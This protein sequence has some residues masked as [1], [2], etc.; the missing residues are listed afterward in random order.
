M[1]CE[2]SCSCIVSMP[3][4]MPMPMLYS[5][6]LFALHDLEAGV[7]LERCPFILDSIDC[8][9][10]CS[11]VLVESVQSCSV[12]SSHETA[13]RSIQTFSQYTTYFVAKQTK[14]WSI[15]RNAQC[16]QR[17]QYFYVF[18]VATQRS[19]GAWKTTSFSWKCS[20][21]GKTCTPFC[22]ATD[23]CT[24]T[25]TMPMSNTGASLEYNIHTHANSLSIDS[26]SIRLLL[27]PLEQVLSTQTVP[28]HRAT[29][30]FLLLL[31]MLMPIP[32]STC[33]CQSQSQ[34]QS[35]SQSQSQ[36]Q[37]SNADMD[38]FAGEHGYTLCLPVLTRCFMH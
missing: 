16:P 34:N 25:A 31:S 18:V 6:G 32:R 27:L 22:K 21:R 3:M 15:S 30:P 5:I 12:Q 33:E 10:R 29:M 28:C 35:Q 26:Q 24:T 2:C 13:V 9:S 8:V 11:V 37:L 19:M 36:S 17:I 4:P 38:T 1:L 7:L 20:G 14:P 23:R